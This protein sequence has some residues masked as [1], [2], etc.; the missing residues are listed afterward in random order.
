MADRPSREADLWLVGAVVLAIGAA[1]V[2]IAAFEFA[3]RPVVLTTERC[4]VIGPATHPDLVGPHLV[5]DC[6]GVQFG[7]PAV[8]P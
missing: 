5:V 8:L 2:S 3:R 1:S 6:D 7:V 4:V